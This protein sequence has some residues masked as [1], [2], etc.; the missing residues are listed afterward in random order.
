MYIGTIYFIDRASYET[1]DLR[2]ANIVLDIIDMK[3]FFPP[4]I[5]SSLDLLIGPFGKFTPSP[6]TNPVLIT[7]YYA[8]LIIMTFQ[9]I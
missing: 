2:A 5:E 8:K 6:L 9:V 7:G 1:S 4:A 3:T